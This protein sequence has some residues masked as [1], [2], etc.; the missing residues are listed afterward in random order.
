MKNPRHV[1]SLIKHFEPQSAEQVKEITAKLQ[2]VKGVL[3]I[4]ISED[5]S[6]VYLKVDNDLLDEEA[7]EAAVS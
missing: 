6:T 7:L 5:D 2:A 3:D 1:S 4:G